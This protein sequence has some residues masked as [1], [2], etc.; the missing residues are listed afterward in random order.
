M[1]KEYIKGGLGD[2]RPDSAFDKKQLR[3]GI[4]IEKEHTPNPKIAKEIAKDH[5][6]EFPD[7]YTYLEEMEKEMVANEKKKIYKF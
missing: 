5:L 4:R 2:G 6:T 7:Y 3:M 1:A